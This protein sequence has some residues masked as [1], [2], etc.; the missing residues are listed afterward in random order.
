MARSERSLPPDIVTRIRSGV[1]LLMLGMIITLVLLAL[2][3]LL[4]GIF[5]GYG[6]VGLLVAGTPLV[7]AAWGLG[8]VRGALADLEAR[9]RGEMPASA[10]AAAPV[11]TAPVRPEEP[12]TA[13]EPQKSPRFIFSADALR[14]EQTSRLRSAKAAPTVTKASSPAVPAVDWEEW[15]GKKLLQK[16][17]I[18]IVLVGMVVL[19]KYSFDNRII[20]ELG[21]LGLAVIASALLLFAGEWYQTRYRQW[22]HSFTGGG[23]ALLYFTVWAARVLY[24]A[25]L[26]AHNGLVVSPWAALILYAFITLVGALAAIRYNAQPIAWFTMLGGYLTPFLMHMPEPHPVALTLYLAVLAAGLLALAWHRRWT[27]LHVPCFLLTQAYLFGQ[28]YNQNLLVSDNAQ[29]GIALGFFAL[30]ASLPLVHQFRLKTPAGNDDAFIIVANGFVTLLALIAAVGGWHDAAAGFAAFGLA[31]AYILFG[32]AA[33]GKRGT[34]T[35]LVNTF[36]A[37]AVALIT[38]ALYLELHIGWVAVGWAPFSALLAFVAVRLRRQNALFCGLLVLMFSL[39]ALIANMPTG[40]SAALWQPF[41]SNWALQSYVVFASLIGWMLALRRMPENVLSSTERGGALELGHALVAGLLFLIVTLEATGLQW[42]VTLNLTYVYVFLA[43]VCVGAFLATSSLVWFAAAALIQLLVLAFTF[44]T[45]PSDMVFGSAAQPFFHPWAGA[46]VAAFIVTCVFLAVAART[47]DKRLSVPSVRTLL[48]A[49]ALA[50]VWIHFSVEIRHLAGALEWSARVFQRVLGGWWIAYALVIFGYGKIAKQ[51]RF[52]PAAFLLLC[53]PLVKDLLLL[54]SGEVGFYETA[55]WTVLPIAI[56]W[57]GAHTRADR[58]QNAALVLLGVWT[59]PDMLLHIGLAPG[60]A[61]LLRTLWTALAA[62]VLMIAGF[63]ERQKVL[64]R[65]SIALFAATT[66]KLLI[67]D[68]AGLSTG[69]RIVASIG[70]GL[71]M[72]GAS[73]LYQRFDSVFAPQKK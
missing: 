52:I 9:Q 30:F 25:P 39:I 19:L 32:G 69:V 49:A 68:F 64:R 61:P 48:V 7:L 35:L 33:L 60:A 4:W 12:L 8:R 67:F 40:E 26:L 41:T 1:D 37:S 62:L 14:D 28:V 54:L 45:G 43:L 73:Y 50:Q 47:K 63:G 3:L 66:V 16:L 21:R 71:L 6:L 15:V 57:Y 27:Y 13:P 20:G 10:V 31:A 36:L 58:T 23:L 56:A 59:V 2:P 17:G 55:L 22:A 18:L 24:A 44:L 46:S 70:T 65:F 11:Q 42:A 38:L 34:D 53:L 51:E 29:I 72:I 5:G